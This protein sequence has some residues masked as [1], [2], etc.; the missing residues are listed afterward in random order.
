MTD[1]NLAT[2][3]YVLTIYE[4]DLSAGATALPADLAAEVAE[5]QGYRDIIDVN[6]P[7][8]SDSFCIASWI[9]KQW[10]DGNV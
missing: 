9:Y 4:S 2:S 6:N 8:E 7:G 1:P 3:S 10:K 5:F